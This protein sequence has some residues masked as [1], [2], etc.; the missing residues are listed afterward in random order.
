MNIKSILKNFLITSTIIILIF[1]YYNPSKTQ[2]TNELALPVVTIVPINKPIQEDVGMLDENQY[3]NF[4]DSFEYWFK[5]FENKNNY[6][7]ELIFFGFDYDNNLNSFN[8]SLVTKS[9]ESL[10]L[11]KTVIIEAIKVLSFV[12]KNDWG[13]PENINGIWIVEENNDFVICEIYFL[14]WEI[15]MNYING[16]IIGKQL[17]KLQQIQSQFE[18]IYL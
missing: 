17:L 4:I 8:L 16:D 18:N 10:I 7:I 1:G 3:Q 2:K 11:D 9:D 15:L 13:L 6:S 12:L 14:E 5:Y